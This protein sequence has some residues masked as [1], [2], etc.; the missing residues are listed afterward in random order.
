M[1]EATGRI[2]SFRLVP[3]E[4]L[5]RPRIDVLASLSGIFRDSF[6]NVMDLLDRL[7]EAAATADEPPEMN[8]IKKHS[9]DMQGKGIERTFSRLFS[10]APGDFG[11]M[12]N[13][14]Y[15][16]CQRR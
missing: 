15:C 5:G 1:Q 16:H 14:V 8:F 10:N 11:S 9:A 12:V 7:F 3:L 2:V 4:Q 13:G 6:E